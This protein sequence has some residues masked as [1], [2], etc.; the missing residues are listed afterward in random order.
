MGGFG[1][2]LDCTEDAPL[3]AGEMASGDSGDRDCRRVDPSGN[4][5]RV[6][7]RVRRVDSVDGPEQWE[8][9]A[10]LPVE[11]GL[12]RPGRGL[13]VA[14]DVIDGRYFESYHPGLVIA[15]DEDGNGWRRID[16]GTHSI[17][18]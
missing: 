1:W 17:Y 3:Y 13:T 6:E 4:T 10:N 18:F 16:Q 7:D 11:G 14:E 8:E 12:Q 15:Y 9:T 5:T 2:T